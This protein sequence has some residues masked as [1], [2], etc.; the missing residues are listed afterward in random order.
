MDRVPTGRPTLHAIQAVRFLAALLVVGYHANI[1]ADQHIARAAD[2]VSMVL[3]SIGRS[4]VHIFFVI[5]GFIMMF[6]IRPSMYLVLPSGS[7]G[8]D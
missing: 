3:A 5:S 6:T 1:F 2:S 7:S 4:G 8:F